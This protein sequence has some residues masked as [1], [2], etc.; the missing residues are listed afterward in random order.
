MVIQAKG[1]M[2]PV[3]TLILRKANLAGGALV[4]A[5]VYNE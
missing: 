3:L 1:M 2:I 4:P 5:S